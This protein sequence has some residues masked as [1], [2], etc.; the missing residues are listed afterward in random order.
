RRCSTARCCPQ[1][2]ASASPTGPST[3]QPSTCSTSTL[4][5]QW[6]SATPT[7]P[8]SSAPRRGAFDLSSSTGQNPTP[9][10]PADGRRGAPTWPTDSDPTGPR[11]SKSV[12][13][14]VCV[15]EG[16]TAPDPYDHSG[17]PVPVRGD[18]GHV[19]GP[20]TERVE[21][22]IDGGLG[23]SLRCPDDIPGGVV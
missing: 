4:T 9:P 18:E 11:E 5:R 22:L 17:R 8:T 13:R 3:S 23:P 7:R 10:P 19:S 20:I 6:S 16:D 1:T 15:S 21:E 14:V 2:T 12:S